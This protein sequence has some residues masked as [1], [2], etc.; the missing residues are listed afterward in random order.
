MIFMPDT[1]TLSRNDL[2]VRFSL[3]LFMLF[4][5][6]KYYTLRNSNDVISAEI[7]FN[8]IHREHGT[9]DM[10]DRGGVVL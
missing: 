5:Y 10:T 8:G 3:V 6:L 9:S 2:R 4:F 7:H 1:W